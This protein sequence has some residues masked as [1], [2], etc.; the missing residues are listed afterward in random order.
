MLVLSVAILR[1]F[2]NLLIK[3]AIAFPLQDLESSWNLFF[4]LKITKTMTTRFG[5]DVIDRRWKVITTRTALRRAEGGSVLA[6]VSMM[7]KVLGTA[8]APP[9][10]LPA[11]AHFWG[12]VF[13]CHLMWAM[14]S[15][16]LI[17]YILTSY[18]KR[19]RIEANL[20]KSKRKNIWGTAKKSNTLQRH[21]FTPGEKGANRMELLN[22]LHGVQKPRR[23]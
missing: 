3:F 12:R 10:F 23:R 17:H 16:L 19:D 14:R 22:S 4:G 11:W 13:P 18:G 21:G 9:S 15:L 5:T 20:V 8:S 6:V 1:K 7:E 2:L